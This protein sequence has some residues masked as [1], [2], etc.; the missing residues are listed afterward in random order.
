MFTKVAVI[1]A[2]VSSA[3]ATVFITSPT[4]TS[5]FTAGQQATVTWKDNGNSP[6]LASWGNASVGI[7]A[8]NANQQTMLQ[9]IST[10]VNVSSTTSIQFVPSASIGPN[11]Q[12]YFIRIQSNTLTDSSN[13]GFPEMSFSALFTMAG[14]TGTFNASVS[15]E[16][17]GQSTAP[18]GGTTS[19][20]SSTASTSKPVAAAST[21]APSS[22]KGSTT[23]T[24]AGP[25]STNAAMSLSSNVW[26]SALFGAVGV[27]SML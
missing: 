15:A 9:S 24:G 4:N 1:S 16:V 18:I 5:T 19:A 23:V 3:F 22:S 10:S 11:G 8:G 25:N 7:W 20:G 12:E 14:M 21:S 27:V 17:A 26:M 13:S 6:S 2:L